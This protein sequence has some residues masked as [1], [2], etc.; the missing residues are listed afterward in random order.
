MSTILQR[1]DVAAE[2]IEEALRRARLRLEPH[3]LQ[4]R[5]DGAVAHHRAEHGHRLVDRADRRAPA[6]R[7]ASTPRRAATARP[8]RRA[9]RRSAARS[10]DATRR[11]R[12]NSWTLPSESASVR[13]SPLTSFVAGRASKSVIS[14]S[15]SAAAACSASARPTGP[16]PIT[17]SF[18]GVDS[19]MR[20]H[21]FRG[22]FPRGEP[23][24]SPHPDV[25][26]LCGRSLPWR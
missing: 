4:R 19:F 11:R 5:D 6:L 13:G 15:G 16:A 14:A 8:A 2:A 20:A 24:Y 12:C 25:R 9:P 18:K 21:P 3:R 7:S 23:Y 17:A 26:G 1:R 10:P 22:L